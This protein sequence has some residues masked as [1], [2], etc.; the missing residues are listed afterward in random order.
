LFIAFDTTTLW[1]LWQ[2]S[3]VDLMRAVDEATY[4][5]NLVGLSLMLWTFCLFAVHALV[6]LLF[7]ALLYRS[8]LG[9]LVD[10]LPE[11]GCMVRLLLPMKVVGRYKFEL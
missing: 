5:N 1:P 9:N 2:H 8:N 10:H 3:L 7:L 11:A 4:K 6:P